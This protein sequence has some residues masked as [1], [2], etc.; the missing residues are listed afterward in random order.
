MNQKVDEMLSDTTSDEEYKIQKRKRKRLIHHRNASADEDEPRTEATQWS[1]PRCTYLNPDKNHRCELCDATRHPTTNAKRTGG[2]EKQKKRHGKALKQPPGDDCPWTCQTCTY[3]NDK[4][5]FKCCLCD[6]LRSRQEVQRKASR[7]EKAATETIDSSD[8]EAMPSQRSS[9]S[10]STEEAVSTSLWNDKYRPNGMVD[11]CVHP[12]KS[13]E[14]SDWFTHHGNRQRILFLC[15]PPGTGKSTMVRSLASK[16]GMDVH[17]WKDN[18][19]VS[20]HK[21]GTSAMD[22]FVA[23]L[24]RSQRYR[25]LSFRESNLRSSHLILIEE[26][27]SFQTNHRLEFQQL[28]QNRLIARDHVAPIVIIYS[29][30][31]EGKVTPAM[32]AKEFSTAVVYSPL[33]H[34]IHCNPIAPGMMKKYLAQIAKRE[35]IVLSSQD[36]SHIVEQSHGDIRHAINTLQFQ[37]KGGSRDPFMSDFHLIGK[38]LHRKEIADDNPL[39]QCN[40]DTARILATVHQNCADCFT[41]IEDLGEAMELFSLTDTLLHSVYHDRSNSSYY[42]RSQHIAQAIL[43]RTIYVT[44]IHPA[45]SAFRPLVR[46]LFGKFRDDA[47]D[48]A[49]KPESSWY[50]D[51][52]SYERWLKTP[53]QQ[54]QTTVDHVETEDEI[55]DSD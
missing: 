16:L 53:G 13:Q 25:S 15:G 33:V 50:K 3:I 41:E 8:D 44:N 22:D 4:P 31:H 30:V 54:H 23:F 6:A 11:L 47:D 1:C 52:R 38:L 40:M 14:L 10:Q 39:R 43:E 12:K 35:R 26:W 9:N 19:G 18:S 5:G 20:Q 55:V 29:D 48:G 32:L 49:K 45:P 51:V 36:V 34:I 24:E 17:E 28:L 7:S 42:E 21:N 37:Q 2:D 46:S 27:P